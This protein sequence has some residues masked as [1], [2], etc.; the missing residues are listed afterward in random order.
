ML[1]AAS[2]VPPQETLLHTSFAACPTLTRERKAA[3]AAAA[4]LA[5]RQ[6]EVWFQNRRA[7][8]KMRDAASRCA[9]LE[10]ENERLRAENAAVR[11]AAASVASALEALQRTA[12]G[13]LAAAHAQARSGA[14]LELP[15]ALLPFF[16]GGAQPLHAASLALPLPSS[17]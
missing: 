15:A 11:A 4:S 1:T 7:R 9:A 12:A 16:G 2:R 10:A 13:A 8:L 6:V 3:L 14:A 17:A 5:P